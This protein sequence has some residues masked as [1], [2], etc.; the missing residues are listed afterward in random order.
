MKYPDSGT[1]LPYI[2]YH[3][4]DPEMWGEARKGQ[5]FIERNSMFPGIA[6]LYE[7]L[8]ETGDYNRIPGARFVY[9]VAVAFWLM[10]AGMLYCIKKKRYNR[11]VPFFLLIGLWGTLMLSPVV[12]FRYGY[13]LIISLPVVYA[14]CRGNI[15][16]ETAE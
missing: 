4:A 8:T 6:Y 12:V 7:K 3:S 10:I 13:P 14:M 16:C 9:S 15:P 5:V 2:P 11:A 1:Y